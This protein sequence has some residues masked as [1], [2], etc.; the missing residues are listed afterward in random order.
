MAGRNSLLVPRA[1]LMSFRFDPYPKM[2]EKPKWYWRTL[3]C[4]PYLLP[5]HEAIYMAENSFHLPPLLG[6]YNEL[7]TQSFM[8]TIV[9]VPSWFFMVYFCAVSLFLIR[10][11]ELPHFFRF[12]VL[13][14]LLLDNVL[15]IICTS[16]NWFPVFFFKG[17]RFLIHFWT[18]VAL[19]YIF[20][21]LECMRCALY[22]AYADVPSVADAA[23]IHTTPEFFR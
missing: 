22:G 1:S 11:R 15:Q 16:C 2:T 12:H 23:Y 17:N 19:A 13:M 7:L 21:V 6:E 14:A 20:T 3:S 8:D 9:L 5:L 4:V 10:R 18:G